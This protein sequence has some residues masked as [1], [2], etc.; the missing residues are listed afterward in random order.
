[1][2]TPIVIA[3]ALGILGVLFIL[4]NP[5]FGLSLYTVFLYVRPGDF[6]SALVPFHVTRLTA[7]ITLLVMV[8]RRTVNKEPIY[9]RCQQANLLTMLGLIMFF[10]ITTSIWK[11]NSINQFLDFLKLYISFFLVI[12]LISSV[13]QFNRIVWI[14]VLSGL[15]LGITS[16]IN[17]SHAAGTTN[18]YRASA[19]VGGVFSNPNDLAL[20][21][22]IL[23]PFAY[24]L[25]VQSRAIFTK[26]LFGFSS[27]IFLFGIVLTKSRG[28]AL[29]LLGVAL[30]L[31]LRSKSKIKSAVVL[32]LLVFLFFA[33][34]PADYVER[35]KSI[36]TSHKEDI[37]TIS[38]FDAWKAGISMMMTRPLGVGIGNFGEAFVLY[39]PADA[40]D[41]PRMRRV[42]H[43][44]FIQIGG[45]IGI[46]G[47]LIF[48]LLLI[49]ALRNL[50]HTKRKLI[51]FKSK[52]ASYISYLSDATF[53]SLIGFSICGLFLSQAYN[54]IF[55]YFIGFSV[56][57]NELAKRLEHAKAV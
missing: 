20:G 32:S 35:I 23:I 21:F 26:I 4:F 28:G 49:S 29:G 12:N 27:V 33:F 42:A 54:W 2:V 3:F 53:L 10:S 24:F 11:G 37:N 31:F 9:K 13:K 22:L 6:F 38:R 30:F 55:Y 50:N 18:D 15:F 44:M 56:V 5:Y 39:R 16:I 41:D 47:L 46:F 17:Y 19:I 14:M 45:E 1:M 51:R 48:L 34:A 25:F 8:F 40:I 36:P 43:N 57:L 7:V 52:E